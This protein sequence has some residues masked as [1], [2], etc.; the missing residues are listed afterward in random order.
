MNGW[1]FSTLLFTLLQATLPAG[2]SADSPA[3]APATRSAGAAEAEAVR[4]TV[5]RFTGAAVS[6]DVAAVTA[7]I[8]VTDPALQQI[9][10]PSARVLV[11][12]EAVKSAM[13]QR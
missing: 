3:T 9:V 7:M 4:T 10:E 12:L 1:C 8:R 2:N 11:A 5:T 6:G 13:D